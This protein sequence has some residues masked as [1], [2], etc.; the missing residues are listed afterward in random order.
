M[1]REEFEKH[2]PMRKPPVWGGSNSVERS[3]AKNDCEAV[4]D[5]I[6][7]GIDVNEQDEYGQTL[8]MIA[9]AVKATE[10][11]RIL[12][13][14]GADPNIVNDDE[15]GP[16]T[17]AV[18]NAGR[19]KPFLPLPVNVQLIAILLDAGADPDQIDQ[20][21]RSPAGRVSH[22]FRLRRLFRNHGYAGNFSSE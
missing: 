16:L 12:L 3:I 17:S 15:A 10:I 2:F 22:S 8:L 1:S 11:V 7:E 4:K 14:A 6:A 21:R 18:R 9:A 13:D 19:S 20:Y 5:A